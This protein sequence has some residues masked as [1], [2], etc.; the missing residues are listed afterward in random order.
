MDVIEIAKQRR[1]NLAR[2]LSKLDEFI[3]MG[4]ELTR[5]AKPGSDAARPA[6]ATGDAAKRTDGAQPSPATVRQF[7]TDNGAAK[8][9]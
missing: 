3:R 7:S 5:S 9:S 4:E 6:A 1:A 2:E 8:T